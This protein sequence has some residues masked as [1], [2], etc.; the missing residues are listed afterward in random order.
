MAGLRRT[1]RESLKGGFPCMRKA[2][3]LGI[4][5]ELRGDDGA[6]TL[7]ALKLKRALE[8]SG[9]RSALRIFHGST[10]P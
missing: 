2:A 7:V 6:G 9:K 1:L 8:R 3:V 5:S 10:A 4:G